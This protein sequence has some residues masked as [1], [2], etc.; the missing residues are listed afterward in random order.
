MKRFLLILFITAVLAATA[1][2]GLAYFRHRGH[3]TLDMP[4]KL[5][6]YED[7]TALWKRVE[8][9]IGGREASHYIQSI[10]WLEGFVRVKDDELNGISSVDLLTAIVDGKSV[11]EIIVLG[12]VACLRD[13]ELTELDN[14]LL[15]AGEKEGSDNI[16]L[17]THRADEARGFR[18]L[19]ISIIEEYMDAK[20][21]HRPEHKVG[22]TYSPVATSQSDVGGSSL[23]V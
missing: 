12:A 9:E 5:K 13:S 1:G 18:H 8:S 15:L 7:V 3:L 16:W 21:T 19:C 2:W 20:P 10:Q 4:C 14:K 22:S 6:S 23:S 11:R 17:Y